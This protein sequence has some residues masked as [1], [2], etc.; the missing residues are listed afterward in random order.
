LKSGYLVIADMVA[1]IADGSDV[2]LTNTVRV[3]TLF[4][5]RLEANNKFIDCNTPTTSSRY[6][7]QIGLDAGIGRSPTRWYLPL[8]L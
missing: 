7:R 5:G 2:P 8:Q 1:D 3:P 6:K 4:N